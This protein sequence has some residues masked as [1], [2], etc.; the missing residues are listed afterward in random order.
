MST[1][2]ESQNGTNVSISSPDTTAALK[3]LT[4]TPQAKPRNGLS[5]FQGIVAAFFLL[6]WLS[7]FA[8][9]IT[10]DTTKFRCAISPGGATQLAAE[11][12]PGEPVGE[13]SSRKS[14]KP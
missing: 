14:R 4:S 7:L 9:G 8:G 5:P 10:M 12:R 1:N 3:P 2:L 11:A 13:L 6:S